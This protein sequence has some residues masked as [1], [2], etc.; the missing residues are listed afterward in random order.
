[1]ADLEEYKMAEKS[2]DGQDLQGEGQAAAAGNETDALQ[3]VQLIEQIMEDQTKFSAFVKEE[4]KT[5]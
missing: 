1:M 4:L 5:I 2:V 3:S